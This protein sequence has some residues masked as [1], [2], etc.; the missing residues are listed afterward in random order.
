VRLDLVTNNLSQPVHVTHAGDG[1]GRLFVIE[2]KGRVMIVRGGAALPTPFLDITPL[3]GSGGSEQGLLSVAFHPDYAAN[4]LLYVYYTDLQGDVAIAR[5]GVSSESPDRADPGSAAKLFGVEKPASNHNGGL[6]LFGPDRYLYVGLGDGGRAG[7]PWGN[8]QNRGALLGKML[9]L[10]VDGGWPYAIPPDNPFA[11]DSAARPEIWAYGLRNPWRFSF[12]R[13][14]GDLYIG[15][16]GQNAWEELDFQRAGSG[17]GQNY[18]WNHMEGRHCFR[19]NP[20]CNAEAY[21]QPI[22]EY[23]L[24]GGNCSIIGG[25]VYRGPSFPQLAG[26]YFFADYCSGRLWATQEQ[27][28][29][30][31]LTQELPRTRLQLSSFGEDEAGEIYVTSLSDSGLYRLVAAS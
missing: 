13:A 1:T 27:A 9:R 11:S 16:V 19:V 26:I 12:D 6:A 21:E 29:G 24:T 17:G 14:T 31:W 2:K 8:A 25:Y 22:V 5:Y 3:V 18:G 15:D 30:D 7:D 4:G 20:T 10:D 23:P 28:P